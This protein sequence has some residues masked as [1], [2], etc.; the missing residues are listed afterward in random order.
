MEREERETSVRGLQRRNPPR[1]RCPRKEK[2]ISSLIVK[3]T[4]RTFRVRPFP[5]KNCHIV[6][7]VKILLHRLEKEEEEEEA[8]CSRACSRSLFAVRIATLYVSTAAD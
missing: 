8:T 3:G 4:A 6:L 7:R 1:R 2:V 5:D